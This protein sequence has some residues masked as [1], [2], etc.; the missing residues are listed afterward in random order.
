MTDYAPGMRAVIRDEEWLIKKIE[1]NSLGHQ[2]LQCVGITPLVRNRDT[3]FLTDL[4]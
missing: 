2:V 1:T 3:I 4:E